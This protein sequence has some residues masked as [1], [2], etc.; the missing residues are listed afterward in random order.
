[1]KKQ[2]ILIIIFFVSIT[3]CSLIGS[4]NK[5]D[6]VTFKTTQ[7]SYALTDTVTAILRNNSKHTIE[8][9]LCGTPLEQKVDG[10]WVFMGPKLAP[11]AMCQS[12]AISMDTGGK[13]SYRLPLKDSTLNQPLPTGTYRLKT[14]VTIGKSN[15]RTL[16]TPPFT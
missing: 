15:D 5:K 14:D 16:Y 9:N 13:D 8:Y 1:M 2:L 10:K 11:E 6:D 7:D 4:S 12:I 3:S